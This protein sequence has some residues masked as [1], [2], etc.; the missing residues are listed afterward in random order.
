[1]AHRATPIGLYR[2]FD[3]GILWLRLTL[4]TNTMFKTPQDDRQSQDAICQIAD[5]HKFSKQSCKDGFGKIEE[6]GL[7][8]VNLESGRGF[9][10]CC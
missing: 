9:L 1:M 5:W 4:F 6:W 3:S 8:M 7:E 10:W 2:V